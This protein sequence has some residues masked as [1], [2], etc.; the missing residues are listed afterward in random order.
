MWIYRVAR[1]PRR[2]QAAAHISCSDYPMLRLASQTRT[3]H[4]HVPAAAS[5]SSH[6]HL[7]ETA[8]GGC[9]LGRTRHE[10]S[11]CSIPRRLAASYLGDGSRR[12]REEPSLLEYRSV[13]RSCE[14]RNQAATS[15]LLGVPRNASRSTLLRELDRTRDAAICRW[16][17]LSRPETGL[18]ADQIGAYP[19]ESCRRGLVVAALRG[20][21]GR[22]GDKVAA[23]H[24]LEIGSIRQVN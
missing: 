4:G 2:L 20:S 3:A 9:A 22:A 6:A 8:G 16:L 13:E 21:F 7:R 18:Q 1:D 12:Q 17:L 15:Q 11:V 19:P 23:R 14:F 5:V 10:V 24:L